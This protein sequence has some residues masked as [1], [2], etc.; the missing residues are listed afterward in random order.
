MH[1]DMYIP[2]A[3][4]YSPGPLYGN[5][6][7]LRNIVKVGTSFITYLICR[8]KR[9]LQQEL[10]SQQHTAYEMNSDFNVWAG[11]PCNHPTS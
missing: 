4:A 10:A 8:Q 7:P 3:P 1:S 6:C 2:C 11:L 5:A 9:Q